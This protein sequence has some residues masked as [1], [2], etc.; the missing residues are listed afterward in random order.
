M[1]SGRLLTFSRIRFAPVENVNGNKLNAL[2]PKGLN[3][4][5]EDIR[6]IAALSVSPRTSEAM[7]PR[8]RS[9]FWELVWL[10]LALF[11]DPDPVNP[12][13]AQKPDAVL[14]S[15]FYFYKTFQSSVRDTYLI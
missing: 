13:G 6:C 12:R 7:G 8:P 10:D 3:A 1:A 5:T 15:S 14:S 9:P 2:A 11:M 4:P